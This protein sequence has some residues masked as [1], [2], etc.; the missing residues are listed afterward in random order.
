VKE[1]YKK[2][3]ALQGPICEYRDF[4]RAPDAAWFTW[5]CGPPFW[6]DLSAPLT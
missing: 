1:P 6:N 5:G 3:R 2:V 4:T